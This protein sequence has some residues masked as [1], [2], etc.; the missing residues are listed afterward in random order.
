M[1]KKIGIRIWLL[2]FLLVLSILAINPFLALKKGVMIS[3]VSQNS[4]AQASGL[5]AGEVIK[6][7]N[8]IEINDIDDY[9][10][11]IEQIFAN[12]TNKTKVS[13]ETD[14]GS[15]AFLADKPDFI[16]KPLPKTRLRLGLELQGGS[17]ALV[18][19]QAETLSEQELE[20]IISIL[21]QRFNRYGISDVRISKAKDLQGKSYILIEI[22]GLSPS[23]LKELI[24]SQG[25]FEA[26]IGNETVFIGGRDIVSVCQ[27]PEC[28]GIISC[29][30][31]ADGEAC[32]FQFAVYLSNDAAKRQ[33]ELTSRLEVNKSNPKY[34]N[35][36]LDLYL[37]DKLVDSL[38]ISAELKG[39]ATTQV[40][41]SGS[42]A[43]VDRQEAY[44]NAE[45]NMKK[46]QTILITG[47][48]PVKLEISKLDSV[49]ALLGKEI[50][51]NIIITSAILIL[52][53]S[54]IIFLRYR[55]LSFS[56]PV[57]LTMLSE[58]III[59]GIAAWIKWNLDL[60]S[61]AGILITIGTGVDAQIVILDETKL[62]IRYSLKERIKRAFGIILGSFAT[63]AVAMLPLWQAGAG[64]LKGF[65]LTTLI[66]LVVGVFITRPAFSEIISKVKGIE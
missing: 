28:S 46:L 47:S 37:D 5:K 50:L 34:L 42:G 66:G 38:L 21:N 7:I 18:V 31:F 30:K 54:I 49:S 62:S 53:V 15:Y 57:I 51:R 20:N 10:K 60:A 4:S 13:I 36:S 56:L 3:E 41:V 25:K 55:R 64:L 6:R 12:K 33:A 45:Q 44:E 63:T 17:R 1:L 27:S 32:K 65:A 43:G 14:K 9:S 19:P 24:L 22:A 40:A 23:Q 35:E 61:I 11:A 52:V 59:L 2:I 48:L 26:R 58:I 8:E 16:V 39:Q 29:N